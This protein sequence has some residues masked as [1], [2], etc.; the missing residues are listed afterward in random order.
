[1]VDF[2]EWHNIIRD[3]ALRYTGSGDEGSANILVI[4]D[5]TSKTLTVDLSQP[6]FSIPFG[7]AYPSAVSYNL[8]VDGGA[9]LQSVTIDNRGDVTI[10]FATPPPASDLQTMS[11]RSRVD[12][13]LIYG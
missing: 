7:T 2:R 12:L 6:P 13:Q 8:G 4:G 5:G 9:P 3:V 10:T 1:M 11:P